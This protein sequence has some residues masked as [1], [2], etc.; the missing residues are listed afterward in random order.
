MLTRG[1][2]RLFQALMTAF[3][4]PFNALAILLAALPTDPAIRWMKFTMSFR[5]FLTAS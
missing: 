3:S 2:P 4:G 1:I 5:T